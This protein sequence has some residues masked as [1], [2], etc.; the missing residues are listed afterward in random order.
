MFDKGLTFTELTGGWG[1]NISSNGSVSVGTTLGV[2]SATGNG[3][4]QGT[5]VCLAKIDVTNYTKLKA[6]CTQTTGKGKLCLYS[7]RNVN[8]SIQ[9]ASAEFSAGTMEVNLTD[10]NG[11]YYIGLYAVGT[12]GWSYVSQIWLEP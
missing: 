6:V 8:S 2:K 9:G 10:Y 4:F 7:S 5:L 12:T 1:S 11:E 3:T